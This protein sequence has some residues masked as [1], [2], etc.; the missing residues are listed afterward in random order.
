MTHSSI[1]S[2]GERK[3]SLPDFDIVGTGE[4]VLFGHPF[5]HDEIEGTAPLR[6]RSGGEKLNDIVEIILN[7][8]CEH[9]DQALLYGQYL[10][11]YAIGDGGLEDS[12]R[13]ERCQR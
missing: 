1:C 6:S 5:V 2:D 7:E 8:M 10:R 11:A 12:R 9:H 4:H 3:E 13:Y